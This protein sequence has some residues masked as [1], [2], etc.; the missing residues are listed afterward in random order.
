MRD[1]HGKVALVTGGAR[2][3]GAEHARCLAAA[4]ARVVLTDVLEDEGRATAAAIGE[5]AVFVAHDVASEVSWLHAL[6]ETQR[7]GGGLDFLINNA[8]IARFSP[9]GQTDVATFE[10]HQRVNE[11][12]VFLGMKYCA[13]LIA[14]R[15]G[16]S[17]VNVSSL[18]GL[19]AG[20]ND[21]AYV[22]SKWA[23]RGM[24]KSAAKELGAQNIR[25][26]SIHPG[27]VVTPMLGEVSPDVIAE[28]A[29]KV[30]LGRAGTVEDIAGLVLFLLS[31]AASYITG[32]EIVIDGGLGL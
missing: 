6:A 15:G 30:P 8:A 26:N 28:R 17:I 11:L 21:I 2:G 22:G 18:G 19:R 10:L 12:G 14:A 32:A 20:G 3:Q 13:P 5:A 16:G 27:L 25:V 1:F 29:A 4:G 31:D 23:V 24:T 7:F 9:I